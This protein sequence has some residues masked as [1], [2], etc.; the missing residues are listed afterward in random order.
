MGK[1]AQRSPAHMSEAEPATLARW[2]GLDVE[3]GGADVASRLIELL[4]EAQMD[5]FFVQEVEKAN[6]E[7][8]SGEEVDPEEPR[9]DLPWHLGVVPQDL[10]SGTLTADLPAG[11]HSFMN[12]SRSG[13][14]VRLSRKRRR[15]A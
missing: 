2:L 13:F 9:K 1:G 6:S 11:F 14:E 4:E 10:A 12:M 7:S 3:I 5:Q 15:N 8:D